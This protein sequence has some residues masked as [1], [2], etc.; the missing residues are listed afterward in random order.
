VEHVNIAN[1][2]TDFFNNLLIITCLACVGWSVAKVDKIGP[3]DIIVFPNYLLVYFVYLLNP[4]IVMITIVIT[5]Y[6][7]HEPLRRN[8]KRGICEMLQ[9]N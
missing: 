1:S 3:T 9:W 2:I 6:A 8:I 4:N 7:R 5:Y